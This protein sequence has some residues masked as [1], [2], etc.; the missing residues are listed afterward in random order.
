VTALT[1]FIEFFGGF[2]YILHLKIANGTNMANFI[3]FQSIYM[4]FI[5]HVFL[6]NTSDNKSRIMEYGWKN[7]LK[8]IIRVPNNSVTPNSSKAADLLKNTD[9]SNAQKS[10]KNTDRRPVIQN[11]HRTTNS[12][13]SYEI[14]TTSIL[15]SSKPS[16]KL[17]DATNLHVPFDETPT[18][19]TTAN[20][21][22]MQR[23]AFG[24]ANSSKDTGGNGVGSLN[25]V[26]LSTEQMSFKKYELDTLDVNKLAK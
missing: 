18:T 5:P 19:S 3:H 24:K 4:L 1:S 15:R 14:V 22:K 21:K 11:Q 6:M 12:E 25:E 13:K 23:N 7:V 10:S 8:N 20:T 17:C 16:T 26:R 2:T 9:S